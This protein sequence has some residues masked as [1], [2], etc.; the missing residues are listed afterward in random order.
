MKR[1]IRML[2]VNALMCL[3]AA[4]SAVA[5][6]TPETPTTLPEHAKV[7]LAQVHIPIALASESKTVLAQVNLQEVSTST[8]L[9]E[10]SI[11]TLSMISEMLNESATKRAENNLESV[12]RNAMFNPEES[13]VSQFLS[14][15]SVK[16]SV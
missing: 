13:M 10:N 1:L 8:L 15:N 9:D 7:V 5:Q 4:C 12:R 6:T 14:A 2:T 11:E 3:V 16:Q